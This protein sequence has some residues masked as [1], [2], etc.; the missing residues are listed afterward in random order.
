MTSLN[1]TDSHQALLAV[2]QV[3]SPP[4]SPS[5]P[6]WW[7]HCAST[8]AYSW[9][10]IWPCR[11]VWSLTKALQH[12]CIPSCPSRPPELATGWCLQHMG[13]GS[14]H[15]G[16]KCDLC[17]SRQCTPIS[18]TLFVCPVAHMQDPAKYVPALQAAGASSITFQ[19]C[20]HAALLPRHQL[21]ALVTAL[22]HSAHR[23]RQWLPH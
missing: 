2:L 17:R 9:T 20:T 21:A 4:T 7:L 22:Q 6:L 14:M 15:A 18:D 3:A 8:A 16:R 10:A 5:G 19:V 13:L 23:K 12:G 11:C 1:T